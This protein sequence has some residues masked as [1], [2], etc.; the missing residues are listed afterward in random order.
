VAATSQNT[1]LANAPLTLAE[2]LSPPADPP[3]RFSNLSPS[4]RPSGPSS[5]SHLRHPSL[6]SGLPRPAQPPSAAPSG[7]PSAA[8][9]NLMS[10]LHLLRARSVPL[11]CRT[12][13]PSC[14]KWITAQV[15]VLDRAQAQ[16]VQ[17]AR[18]AGGRRTP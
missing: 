6:S 15:R 9:R 7:S 4:G 16:R 2:R 8:P 13:Q 10:Q 3:V 12:E 14:R 5:L 1:P 17:T 11:K 18:A